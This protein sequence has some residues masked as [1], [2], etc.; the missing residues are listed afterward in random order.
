MTQRHGPG[1]IPTRNRVRWTSNS[2]SEGQ[3]VC[4]ESI[5]GHGEGGSFPNSYPPGPALEEGSVTEY[6][7]EKWRPDLAA[8]LS[9]DLSDRGAGCDARQKTTMEAA[10]REPYENLE[11]S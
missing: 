7:K 8:S 5:L 6:Y 10:G 3:L 2:R 9:W 4:Y 11:I 1:A